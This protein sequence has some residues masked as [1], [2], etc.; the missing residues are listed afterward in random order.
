MSFSYFTP[1]EISAG[2]GKSLVFGRGGQPFIGYEVVGVPEPA[3]LILIGVGL[4]LGGLCVARRKLYV[5]LRKCRP[6]N[7]PI[8][9]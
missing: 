4:G 5:S 7:A 8:S 3:S 6:R 1:G 9:G 2:T